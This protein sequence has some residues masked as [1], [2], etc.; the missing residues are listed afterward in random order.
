MAVLDEHGLRPR[1]SAVVC[2]RGR[3]SRVVA[4]IA[5]ILAN[6]HPDFELVVIDQSDIDDTERA[7][8]HFRGDPRLRYVR[9]E[10][11]GLGHARN[12]GLI[13]AAGTI[14]AFTD[15]D[16]TVP[17][18]W[19]T[20]VVSTFDDHPRAGVVF[21]N[22]FA[23]PHDR[24][25]GFVPDY[26]RCDTVEVSTL[27]GKL[28][29]RGIGAGQSVRREAMVDIGG[30]DPL[31]GAGALF[32]SAEDRDVAL[33]AILAGWHVVETSRVAVVHDGFRTWEQGRELTRRDWIGLGAAHA[34]PVRAG[35]LNTLL[36]VFWEG[37]VV[38]VIK[39]IADTGRTRRLSGLRQ[40]WYFGI[41]FFRG[42]RHPIDRRT[43]CFVPRDDRASGQLGSGA[44]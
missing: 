21:S 38:A 2:T 28:R 25:A 11:V 26:V 37:V 44:S 8:Q 42:W 35:W 7:V 6:D 5:S 16:V 10:G 4:T 1:I 29:A 39:P 9:S 19:L 41:G 17:V 13:A 3:G 27:R 43:L 23:A 31:L 22:V 33:R 24:S 18:D 15:D 36:V 20:M 14:I 12:A 34:K 30:F 32:S 40:G